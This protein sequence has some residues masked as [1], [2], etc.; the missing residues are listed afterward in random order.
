MKIPSAGD[1]LSTRCKQL[2]GEHRWF[3]LV[4]AL[5]AVL[6]L[7]RITW[8]LPLAVSAET[9]STWPVDTIA[10]VRPLTEAFFL[11]SRDGTD[12]VVYPLL[13]FVV[14][15]VFYGPYVASQYVLGG[16]GS[17]SSEFPFGVEN[18]TAF[19]QHLTII[20]RAVSLA[21]ALGII[22][23][24]YRISEEVGNRRSAIMAAAF[25]GLL[26]PL[27]FY[28]GTSNLDVPYLFWS[29]LAVLQ[30]VLAWKNGAARHY[31][32]FG[33]FAAF[34][35]AT[36]DQAYGFFL[37]LPFALL[38][39]TRRIDGRLLAMGVAGVVAFALG[40]NLLF[41]GL[42]GFLR[43]LEHAGTIH[44]ELLLAT[45]P[46]MYTFHHQLLLLGQSGQIVVGMLGLGTTAL[47][48]L[49]LFRAVRDRR[50]VALSLLLIV[51]TYHVFVI[52]YA[53][54]VL[55]R[56][57]LGSVL[58]LLPFAGIAADRLL[59]R[60]EGRT[61]LVAG[62]AL[63]SLGWQLILCVNLG[64]TLMFDSRYAM[65]DWIRDNL[66]PG[67]RIETQVQHRYLP[68]LVDDYAIDLVGNALD[69]ITY[70]TIASELKPEA[71]ARRNPPYILVLENLGVTGD[72]ARQRPA[73]RRYFD[74]L[75]DGELGYD[76]L[77]RFETPSL[78]DYRQVTAGTR[79]TSVLLGRAAVD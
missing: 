6:V 45:F 75:L 17:P 12:P 7:S 69:V 14:L 11:F 66:E 24:V 19:F 68:H 26:A 60:F 39:R 58:V 51:A 34:A 16:F 74:K 40:N 36:K 79:P 18:T 29:M 54:V 35:V 8:G 64:M 44:E 27:T 62:G 52:M 43:H 47:I 15:D 53:G 77:A 31:L 4:S 49:G 73:G 57:L 30:F 5:F 48:V 63:F 38:I 59:E 3:L 78:L 32:L 72:P 70:D 23:S 20:A 76:V 37:A 71:L 22:W 10:P 33:V 56:Y 67:S 13:H 42:D 25:A 2:A 61:A 65:E 50:T 55:P 9:L 28:A 41:G 21:M 46:D 1:S